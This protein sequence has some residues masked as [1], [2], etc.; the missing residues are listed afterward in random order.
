MSVALALLLLAFPPSFDGVWA[1]GIGPGASATAQVKLTL[2]IESE[3]FAEV[4]TKQLARGVYRLTVL[5]RG[6]GFID[7]RTTSFTALIVDDF[8][9]MQHE[10][11]MI[12]FAG[13]GR[14][15]IKANQAIAFY[16]YPLG[17]RDKDVVAAV[18][19]RDPMP[20]LRIARVVPK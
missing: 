3:L 20:L 15:E 9:V 16:Q 6:T 11:P 13:N 1:Q 14:I 5:E 4:K 17:M 18:R 19:R 2:D 8:D 12:M 10:Q 7:A